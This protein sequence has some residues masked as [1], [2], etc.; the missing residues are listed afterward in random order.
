MCKPDARIFELAL[1]RFGVAPEDCLF[2]DDVTA[3]VA[4]AEAAGIAA[5]RFTS[6][7]ALRQFLSAAEPS[8]S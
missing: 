8:P 5:I 7:D 1:R 3:N 2:I 4:G 6:A